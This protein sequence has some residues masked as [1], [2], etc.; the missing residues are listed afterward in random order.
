MF[1]QPDH[2]A[3][4]SSTVQQARP[5]GGRSG[6]GDEEGFFVVGERA[7]GTGTWLLVE[8]SFEIA[9]NVAAL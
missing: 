8:R 9:F 1:G 4:T 5:A 7:I 2:R 3:A 6:G